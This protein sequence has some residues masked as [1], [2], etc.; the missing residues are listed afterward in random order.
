MKKFIIN[1]AFNNLNLYQIYWEIYSNNENSFK[2]TNK[3]K[4]VKKIG[5]KKDWVWK[6]GK[7]IDSH[8]FQMI[9]NKTT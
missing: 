5:I 6:N 2:L 8:Q 4:D 1:Y 9:N 3:F 7:Y